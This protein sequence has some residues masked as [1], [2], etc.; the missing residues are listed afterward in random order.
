M[1]GGGASSAGG[2]L[3]ALDDDENL[4]DLA[5]LHSRID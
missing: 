5:D 1:V 2:A 3:N 4:P